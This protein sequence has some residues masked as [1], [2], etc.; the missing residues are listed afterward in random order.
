MLTKCY[1]EKLRPQWIDNAKKYL[2]QQ[3][4]VAMKEVT[5]LFKQINKEDDYMKGWIDFYVTFE[6]L[7]GIEFWFSIV[8]DPFYEFIGFISKLFKE[9]EILFNFDEEGAS[10]SFVVLPYEDL[11]VRFVGFI[12]LELYQDEEDGEDFQCLFDIVINKEYLINT[13]FEAFE[14]FVLNEYRPEQWH[15]NGYEPK[16]NLDCIGHTY[17]TFKKLF[18]NHKNK[19]FNRVARIKNLLSSIEF[20][21]ASIEK[22]QYVQITK[23]IPIEKLKS[24]FDIETASNYVVYLVENTLKY[25]KESKSLEP[26][27]SEIYFKGKIDDCQSVLSLLQ[28]EYSNTKK[29]EKYIGTLNKKY[30][31]KDGRKYLFYDS[32]IWVIYLALK[33]ATEPKNRYS[34]ITLY[35]ISQYYCISFYSGKYNL[36]HFSKVRLKDIYTFVERSLM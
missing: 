5:F 18:N 35:Y 11:Q 16:Y 9:E 14:L 15:F 12:D 33:Y 20:M 26:H 6:K 23:L 7:Y 31:N 8:Y 30:K 1:R 34:C 4:P 22:N 19:D 32:D 25:L 2:S 21:I 36:N 24:Y 3:Q 13:L 10:V 27:Q 17:T 28:N 29:I